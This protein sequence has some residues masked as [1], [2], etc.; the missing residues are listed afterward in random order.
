MK[1]G[2]NGESALESMLQL[3]QDSWEDSDVMKL[4]ISALS[5]ERNSKCGILGCGFFPFA[6]GLF[7]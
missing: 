2:G 1:D 5:Q 3:P 6:D 4:A 7:S